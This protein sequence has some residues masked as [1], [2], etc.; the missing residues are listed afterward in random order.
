MKLFALNGTHA[1]GEGIAASLG[2][3]LD[4]HEERAFEDG[5]HKVRALVPVQGEEVFVV[6]SL[7]SDE[8]QSV[9]DKLCRLLF[10][11]GSL[12][13]AGATRVTAIVPY[14]CYSRKDRRTKAQD[15]ITT[16]YVARL[17]EAAGTDAIMTMEVHN[18]QAFE[19]AFRIP[20]ENL[21]TH[22]LLSRHLGQSL[23][24]E[25]LIIVSP[26]FGGIKRAERFREALAETIHREVDLMFIEKYR[27]TGE[28]SGE[29][30]SGSSDV[31][32]RTAIIIDDLISTGGTLSRA[33]LA[34]RKAGAAKVLAFA[35]HGLFTGNAAAVLSGNEIDELIV[36]NTVPAFRL[37]HSEV[38]KKVKVLD[39]AG[40]IGRGF[41]CV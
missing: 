27:S 25:P 20:A 11:I 17:F 1:L 26:D 14:L 8:T 34:C 24:D 36:T 3:K 5:E 37:E 32:G 23:S 40:E 31:K 13:D 29:R 12:K 7:Y 18:L 33:A 38:R 15:P 10:F 30:I 16:K 28:I 21:E 35:T 41:L 39:V 4:A 9:N 6:H 19:N 22:N 2:R